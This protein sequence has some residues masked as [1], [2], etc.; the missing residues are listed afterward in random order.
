VSAL[1]ELLSSRSSLDDAEID[2]LQR[3]VGEWQL[4]S[5]LAFA[6]LLLWIPVELADSEAGGQTA[7]LCAAQCRPTTG[8]T[9]YQHDQ[10]GVL[11][12]GERA[13][14]LRTAFVEGRIFRET[15]PDWD[16]DLP[17]R[18]EAI[19]IR[20]GGTGGTGRGVM[21]VL[22]KDANLASVRTPPPP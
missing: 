15:E 6:D 20:L 21:A 7:F 16:G 3:L 5:D 12:R 1:S 9:A 14:P 4:L 13:T 8:P 18:R 19:P 11:L 2:H 10:V 17:I 22:G